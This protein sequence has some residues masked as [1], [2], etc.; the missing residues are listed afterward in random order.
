MCSWDAASVHG[1]KVF[2]NATIDS[3]LSLASLDTP[4]HHTVQNFVGGEYAKSGAREEQ[5]SRVADSPSV[6][7]STGQNWSFR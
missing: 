5:L 4:M 2:T 3:R 6:P 1:S 7:W